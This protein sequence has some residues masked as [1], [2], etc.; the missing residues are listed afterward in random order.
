ML[1]EYDVPSFQAW[2]HARLHVAGLPEGERGGIRDGIT[3]RVGRVRMDG[4]DADGQVCNVQGNLSMLEGV[5]NAEEGMTAVLVADGPLLRIGSVVIFEPRKGRRHDLHVESSGRHL[6][7]VECDPG[8]LADLAGLAGK[9]IGA[10]PLG[11]GAYS[12]DL[13]PS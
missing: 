12:F 2:S 7:D 9:S 13:S 10:L 8:I 11:H 6:L 1:R 5:G 4:G 3:R